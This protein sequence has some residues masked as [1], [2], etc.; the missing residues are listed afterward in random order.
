MSR[1]AT[2]HGQLALRIGRS[3]TPIPAS[4]DPALSARIVSALPLPG[5][6]AGSGLL[7]IGGRLLALQDDAQALVWID[8]SSLHL[9]PLVLSGSGAA[10]AKRD[11]PDYEVL[12]DAGSSGIYAL[13][14]GSRPNRRGVARLRPDAGSV[15]IRLG[16]LT[17]LHL[18]LAEALGGLPNLEGGSLLAGGSRLRLFHRG[19][20]FEPDF[21][22]DFAAAVLDGAEPELL[23]ACCFQLGEIDGVRL[24]ITDACLGSD[25][26]LLFTAA[27]ENTDDAV[28]DGPVAGA[29]LGL[30][31]LDADAR[32]TAI[33][34]AP[35]LDLDG[36]QSLHKVE[37]IALAADGRCGWL[38]T[39]PDDPGRPAVLCR[40]ALGGDWG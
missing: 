30:I 22:L 26:S 21:A 18:C 35:L 6:R 24:H 3:A 4:C 31:E 29:A 28:A 37:G 25:G 14:S 36:R 16:E 7:R 9:E 34:W 2:S 27:A 11:K 8:P 40:F 13:G 15:C 39:D 5:L 33:R 1:P 32:P 20:G 17:A 38:I 10:Q 12:I 19:A 23:A